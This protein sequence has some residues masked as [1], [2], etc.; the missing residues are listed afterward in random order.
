MTT[1]FTNFS[2]FAFEP[3]IILVGPPGS[4]KGTC[5]QHLRTNYGYTHISIGDVLRNEVDTQTD[6]GLSIEEL[7]KKGD[8]VDSTIIHAI[9]AK[10]IKAYLSEPLILDGFGRIK[11]DVD[12]IQKLLIETDQTKRTLVLFLEA[13]DQVCQDR[14]SQRLV[15]SGCGFVYNSETAKPNNPQK[16]SLCEMAL[17]SRLNDTPEV[18]LKRLQNYRENVEKSYQYAASLFPTIY[19]QS[20]GPCEVCAHFYDILSKEAARSNADAA[21]FVKTF[22]GD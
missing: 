4:G 18:I 6:L 3:L 1:F 16:C 11:E 21:S 9:L 15:C 13:S 5:S 19:Y 7:L 2:L 22:T 17:K 12:V 8:Y 14:I 10:N 20:N